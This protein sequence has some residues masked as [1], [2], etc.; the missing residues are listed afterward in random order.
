MNNQPDKRL[1]A[2]VLLSHPP[3]FKERGYRLYE[4]GKSN[5]EIAKELR[6]PLSTINRW[7]SKEKWKLRKQL[8]GLH[9]TELGPGL[10]PNSSLTDE[11][12][13]RALDREKTLPEAQRDYEETMQA[14]ALRIMRAIE[15]IPDEL[16]I[17]NADRIAKLDL[18]ARKALKLDSNKPRQLIN[19]A[20][21]SHGVVKPA[22]IASD[23]PAAAELTYEEHTGCKPAAEPTED[24]ARI[25]AESSSQTP[26]PAR[27][28]TPEAGL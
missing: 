16:L 26:L 4:Q 6:I 21:L 13:Q 10:V 9:E 12:E 11:A 19:I 22:R 23:V 18:T 7:S 2:G 5:P 14:Q 8:A 17:A 20:L 27:P 28:T 24:A 15:E 1:P 3:E 25:P